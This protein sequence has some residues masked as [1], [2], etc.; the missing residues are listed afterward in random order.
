MSARI[1]SEKGF[2]DH[3]IDLS[4]DPSRFCPRLTN[5]RIGDLLKVSG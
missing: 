4:I 1:E 3:F 5:W 2:V